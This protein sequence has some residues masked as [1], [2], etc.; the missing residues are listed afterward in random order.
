MRIIHRFDFKGKD[1]VKG[2]NFEGL[3]PIGKIEKLLEAWSNFGIEEI[4]FQGAT[5]SLHNT[6]I[7]NEIVKITKEKLSIPMTVGG[8][9]KD[10]FTARRLIMQGADRIAINSAFF[11]KK[12][13]INEIIKDLGESTIVFS[14]DV[15]KINQVYYCFKN[16]GRENTG[17]TLDEYLEE[18][19][20][21]GKSEI[22][23]TN[24]DNDGLCKGIDFNLVN[25]L[26]NYPN[27][28]VYSGGVSSVSD[29]NKLFVNLKNNS[30]GVSIGRAFHNFISSKN[31]DIKDNNHAFASKFEYIS[32]KGNQFEKS[33]SPDKIYKSFRN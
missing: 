18:I 19:K 5:T 4:Q 12:G 14:I 6:F 31:N 29:I 9:I 2:I 10:L 15:S 13:F 23:I 26:V 3:R 21:K 22:L 32:Y 28:I 11:E 1:V 25:K 17:I 33:L 24:I 20:K 30:N 16:N 7:D 8:G 27:P